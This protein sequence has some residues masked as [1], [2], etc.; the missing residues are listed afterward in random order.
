[1]DFY[2][3]FAEL[4]EQPCLVVGGG[5]VALRKVQELLTA[6]ARVTVNAPGFVPEL[7]ALAGGRLRLVR[8]PFDRALVA[9]HLLII[10]ATSDPNVNRDVAGVAR[11]ALRL[12][13]V[14]DDAAASGFIVPAV[15]DRSPLIVAVASGGRAPVLARLLRQ[16]LERALPAGLG[17]LA[18]FAGGLRPKARSWLPD[19]RARRVFWQR[20][21]SGQA[22]AEVLAGDEISAARTAR[23]LAAEL[24]RTPTTGRAWLVGAGP[25]DP[26]LISVR[27][28]EIL[29]EADVVL[30]D[31]LVAPELLH[32]VRREAQVVCVGKAGGRPSTDQ[33]HINQLLIEH[34]RAG[35]RVCRLKGGDPFVFGRGG[36]EAAALAA[37]GLPFEI[38]P[39]ITAA[40]GC[41]AHAGIPLTHRGLSGAVTLVTATAASAAREPDWAQLATARHTLVVYM[42]G[43]RLAHVTGE[44]LRHGCPAETPAALV[45]DG[46]SAHQRVYVGPVAAFAGAGTPENGGSPALLIVGPTAALA[47]TLGWRDAA[48]LQVPAGAPTAALEALT[49]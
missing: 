42:G 31:R 33:A 3:L 24:A 18:R 12:C 16:E 27:G 23:A 10:A 46:T 30:H 40:S 19:P 49:A 7:E 26:G 35:R 32:A 47:R 8:G 48:I 37:A 9:T 39:G 20:L 2:P 29:R 38:V 34:V 13:N 11:T 41:G 44:L 25:G 1:M 28:L 43:A 21:L 5:A 4:R 17:A 14:V 45:V 6:G 22:G 15:V 36:E